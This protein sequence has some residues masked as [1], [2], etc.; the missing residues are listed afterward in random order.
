MKKEVEKKPKIVNIN[1]VEGIQLTPYDRVR[2]LITKSREGSEKLMLGVSFI[3]PSNEP[4]SWSYVE[5]DEV[6][7][8]VRGKLKIQWNDKEA[9]AGEGDAVFLPAGWKYRVTNPGVEPTMIVYVLSP[10]IE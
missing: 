5:N 9:T 3:D 8:V 2:R 1:E 6:Y 7:F 4:Y 10:P